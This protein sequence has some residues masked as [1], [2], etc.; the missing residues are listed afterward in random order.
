M[1]N[2][3]YVSLHN[4]S[5][6]GSIL[7]SMALVE[8]Y[9]EYAA[10]LGMTSLGLS[11]HGSID[12]MID[13][14]KACKKY[15]ITPTIGI[16][17]YLTP[18]IKI[19][20]K[21]EIRSHI[22]T[23]A[24]TEEGF[25]NIV[26]MISVSNI[27]GFF[28]RPRISPEILLNHSEGLVFLSGCSAT[29]LHYGYGRELL[30]NLVDKHKDDVYLEIMAHTHKEQIV[31]NQLCLELS[32]KYNL[33]LVA[34][35][36]SHYCRKSDAKP[37]E[38]LLAIG[39]KKKMSDP[40]R[41]K[42]NSSDFYL[43]S[44][45]EM[46]QAFV[47]Q[48]QLDRDIF[49]Q[50]IANTAEVAEKCQGFKW[51][52]KKEPSLPKI[53]IIGDE[54]EN[55]F[56]EKLCRDNFNKKEFKD[57]KEYQD[58]LEEELK[59][60]KIKKYQRYFLV[61]W[62]LVRWCHSQ[63]IMTSP[64]RG[65]SSGS[66]CAYL[67]GITGVDPIKYG[68]IFSRFISE[69]R[70]SEPDIDFDSP[71]KDRHLV[72]EYLKNTYGEY[73]V[74]GISTFSTMKGRGAMRDVCRAFEVPLTEVNKICSVI[75]SK[76]DG[77]EGSG[78]T[79]ADALEQYDEGR[80][81]KEKYPE[82][83]DI[84]VA[85]EG[86]TRH[87]G[88]HAA[89]LAISSTDL[90]YDGN[91]P[92]V[93][94]K[95]KEIVVSFEK[96]DAEY[97]GVLKLDLL[98]LRALSV[99]DYARKLI[100]KNHDIE[101]DYNSIGLDDPKCYSEISKG[102]GTAVFQFGGPNMKKFVKQLGVDDFETLFA[103]SAIHRPGPM[104][105]GMTESYM[106]RKNGLE[107]IPIQH[108]LIDEITKS[109]Q[110]VLIYQEQIMALTVKIAGFTWE[111]ADQV[112]KVMAKSKGAEAF[113]AFEKKFV[114]GC[115]KL[116]TLREDKALS[117]WHELSGSGSYLFNKSHAV[118]Y[119]LLSYWNLWLKI[120]YPLE[121]MVAS[122]TYGAEDDDQRDEYVEEIF[123]LGLEIRPPKVGISKAEEFVIYE[124]R[125]YLPFGS[126]KG[127]GDKTSQSFEKLKLKTEAKGFAKKE[128]KSPVSTRFLNILEK[129]GAYE[130]K[131]LTDEEADNVS[132]YLGVSLVRNKLFKYKKLIKLISTNLKISNIKD[133]NIHDIDTEYRY[134]FGII[135]ELNLSTKTGKS[136]KYNIASASFKDG[137]G[138]ARIG[139][140]SGFYQSRVSEVEHCES[141][142][143]II[144]ANCPKR[145]GSLVIADAWFQQ[146]IMNADLE[147]L[148]LGLAENRRYLVEGIDECTE[149]DNCNKCRKKSRPK[150]GNYNIM[151]VDETGSDNNDQLWRELKQYDFISRDFYVTSVI[152]CEVPAKG[153]TKKEVDIC[154]KYL[155]EEIDNVRPFLI[156]SIGN[157]GL[158]AFTDQETG[159]QS[160]NGTIEYNERYGCW[161]L[162]CLSPASVFYETNVK[163]F[164]E[165][166]K[167]FQQKIKD[168]GLVC[169]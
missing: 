28:Y 64:G 65:S 37:H 144:K 128:E 6:K 73:N 162:Y 159:I 43:R 69:S 85:L 156:L 82:V 3:S 61:V 62:D 36:D 52:D 161:I 41:W 4:H 118:V 29:P 25:K 55:I 119:T 22:L 1:I 71:S 155:E 136:G 30:E 80:S 149:C 59:L 143:I 102:Y 10:E 106:K 147:T 135:T 16:E 150:N 127:V 100:K 23:F 151:V 117:I 137:T 42:F 121:Y 75:E 44:R 48:G 132:Q 130:D 77:E 109:T 164:K 63:D 131:P 14:Q 68:L 114:E 18:D 148:Y 90:R 126:I 139:F 19:K 15:D 99:L 98:G 20:E 122:L 12:D 129:I 110:G 8:D 115:V 167:I 112:R 91:C 7:D 79:I 123:R 57:K 101:I 146:D 27:E 74:A 87:K 94:N 107:E 92:L 168:L 9:A 125:V 141:E 33:K 108:P 50:A 152:K 166:I 124:G 32:E 11:N 86:Q 111:E 96:E 31:T 66:L 160:K 113:K 89:G 104:I 169:F 38:S 165:T 81:F 49:G 84:A 145:A 26:K 54:D 95:D 120:Y 93:L 21:G 17:W 83:A 72:K 51:I 35:N 56:F 40:T 39:T 133:V 13:F 46:V 142:I 70:I 47:N 105:G 2:M 116:G 103:C 58:R 78:N 88:Q 60:I 153:V 76:L 154:M 24:K 163:P 158:K 67:L 53:H 157:V 34:T 5:S 45:R 140:D 138:D 97:R 134:Y